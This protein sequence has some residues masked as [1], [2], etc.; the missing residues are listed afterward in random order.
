[1]IDLD[2]A[3]FQQRPELKSHLAYESFVS[4]ASRPRKELIVDRNLQGRTM[5]SGFLLAISFMLSRRLTDW[6]SKNRVGIL[7]PPGLGAYIANLAVVLAGK[8]P[9]N[10]NFTLGPSSA[11]ACLQKAEVD[12]LLTSEQVQHKIPHFPW[13]ESGI[14]DLVEEMKSM[15]KAK[16]LAL[17]SWIHLCPAKLLAKILKVPAKGGELEAGL[18]FTSGSSGEPKGVVLSHRNILGNCA[19]IDATG[20]LPASEKVMANL[21]I[22]H[23]FGF[24]VTLWYPLLR[25]CTVVTLASP[26]DV[27]KVA[28]AI[29]AE[30]ATILIGTPTF[31]RPYM[32]R[33]EPEQ[34]ASLKYVIAGAEK[35]PNGFADAWEARFGSL[36]LEGY[37]LTETSPVVSINTPSIP[38]GVNYPS[39]S[40]E[41]SRR[42]SVGRM[43]PGHAARI[44]NPDTMQ[45]IEVTAAGLL[46]LKGPNIFSG[47]LGEPE[48]TA[49]VMQGDWFITG[50]LARF[51]VDGFLFIEGR[52]SR[53]SKIAG[54]MVPHGTV[55]EALIKAY[56]LLDVERP[57]IAVAGRPD[58]AKG[59]ALV[60]L[61]AMDLELDDV[62][63]KL[64][65]AGLANLWIPKEIKRVELIPTLATGKLDLRQIQVLA[66]ES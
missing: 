22:F 43:M 28:E 24:T 49:E 6:T 8:V 47:Y 5:K 2:E 65:S 7:F 60:L 44:L 32:K 35:T 40:T 37:G 20:L 62:R 39:D 55:E 64:S 61:A 46:L 1:M 48:R 12:C 33:V 21:P 4:L 15:P 59:E 23:S 9:V 51:D 54:E 10:L 50:D 45:D 41:G 29:K 34:L 13:P 30:S 14:I 27:K 52:L 18:L 16:T 31:L 11:A 38:K 19:Q 63:E 26:L 36:Y 17:L 53:F 57:I 25:G 66:S 58:K 3:A 42:G 56:N